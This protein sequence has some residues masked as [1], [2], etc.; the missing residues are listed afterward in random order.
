MDELDDLKGMWNTEKQIENAVVPDPAAVISAAQKRKGGTIRLKVLTILILLLTLAG[1]AAFFTYVAKFNDLT[2]IIGAWLMMGGLALR[3]LIEL[4][5]IGVSTRID[6][7]ET[8][9]SSNRS[10]LKYYEFRKMIHGPVTISILVLYTIGFYMLT[11]EFSR[12]FSLPVMILIDISYIVG[13][14][15]FGIAIRHGIKKEMTLLNAIIKQ[16]AE[17]N[18]RVIN[19]DEND[20]GQISNSKEF[21]I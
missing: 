14:V 19:P 16:D 17:L 18:D 2:S 4:I 3:I 10:F 7:S 9:S 15:I 5:S 11:P 8:S 1:I 6:L 13:A 21:K 20:S 12:Y